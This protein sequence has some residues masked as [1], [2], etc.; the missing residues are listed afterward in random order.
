[1]HALDG[2]AQ[3]IGSRVTK[4]FNLHESSF[5]PYPGGGGERGALCPRS[6]AQKGPQSN[7]GPESFLIYKIV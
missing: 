6:P 2:S 5:P 4:I 1:M 3:N 7:E